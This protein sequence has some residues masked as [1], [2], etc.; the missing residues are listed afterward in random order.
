ML[1]P[2]TDRLKPVL[3]ASGPTA[4][5]QSSIEAE[6]E[7]ISSLL[8]SLRRNGRLIAA[9][10][11][12]GATLIA[13]VVTLGMTPQYSSLVTVLVDSRKAPILKDQEVLGRPGTENSAIESEAEILKSPA[14]LRQVAQAMQLDQDPEF[15]PSRGIFG[16]AKW[17]VTAP[18]RGVFG[19]EETVGDPLTPVVEALKRK[20]SAKRRTTTYVIE[21]TVWSKDAAK[22]ALLA[23]KIAEAYLADQI[24]AKAAAAGQATK[25]L[26][27][28]IDQLRQRVAASE[29]AYEHYKA[30]AG[31]FDPGGENLADRQIAQLNEQLVMARAK[32]AEA[33]AKY[34][35]LQALSGDKLRSAAASP[36]LL[37]SSVL[38]HLRN[39]YA[40]VARK[41]ADLTTRYGP[42]HP[43]VIAVRAEQ[44]NLGQ[45]IQ[46]EVARI[47]ASARTEFEMAK[48]REESLSSSLDELTAKATLSHQKS[49]RLRE[50][51]REATANRA[52]L[53]AFLARAKETA[54]QLS[55]QMPDS[56]ILAAAVP[57]LAPAY[58]QKGLLI[59]L[60]FFGSLG[61]GIFLALI[62]GMLS[63]GVHRAGELQTA[64]GLQ[65]LATI[66]LVE[67]AASRAPARLDAAALKASTKLARLQPDTALAE[68]R[69]LANLVIREPNSLF[70]ESIQSLR[71]ALRHIASDRDMK[72]ILITS[73]LPGEGKSTIAVNLARAAA[74]CGDRVL[75]IDADLRRPS[76][77]SNLGFAPAPG[78]ADVLAGEADLHR[79][80]QRDSL[81]PMHLLAGDTAVS[82]AEAMALLSSR[83]LTTLIATARSTYDLVLLDSAP[84]LPVADPRV[85]V[86]QVDGVALVVA[87]ELTTKSAVRAALQE[88]PGIETKILG[89]VMNRVL[90]DYARTYSEYGSF[91]KVA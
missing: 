75:L 18:L 10:T 41:G 7:A 63:E 56:R 28:E 47:I 45:Q 22:S 31:L 3:A 70:A 13:A 43:Q 54:A 40:E 46:E 6:R 20:V 5:G 15:R 29:S 21:L 86:S 2:N 69:H 77:A 32:A 68:T 14:L 66:P 61:M 9:V 57:P 33:Q 16:W 49:V 58:P 65:P 80:V 17:I 51:E 84:L 79:A 36:D 25:W 85:L 42:R 83:D 4:A 81:S 44:S 1:L 27:Q 55:M 72:A 73:A 37:Q 30:E 11:I 74:L 23:N 8:L 34:R 38:G 87:S 26:N 12:L 67:S 89:S 90:V 39:Q 60:G 88:T 78:L 62:R 50:L 76:V 24:A 71:L 19:R 53:E 35:Q 82:G 59:G 48:S 64:F 91:F 52:L